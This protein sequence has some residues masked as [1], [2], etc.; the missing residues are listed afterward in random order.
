VVIDLLWTVLYV[1][2]LLIA[3]VA[4]YGCVGI[5][6]YAFRAAI[7]RAAAEEKRQ[8]EAQDGA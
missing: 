2:L 4:V 3:I 8:Q 7:R 6:F 5:A 1:G